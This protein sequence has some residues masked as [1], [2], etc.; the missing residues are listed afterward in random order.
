MP[1]SVFATEIDDNQI[2]D[3]LSEETMKEINMQDF[4]MKTF[5]TCSGIKDVLDKY[6]KK[7]PYHLYRN[8][9]MLDSVKG[10]AE[11]KVALPSS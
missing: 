6:V 2:I 5:E 3:K 1:I 4:K 11:S 9:M 8:D 7:N 10:V